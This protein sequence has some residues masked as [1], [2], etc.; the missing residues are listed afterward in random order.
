MPSVNSE[1]ITSSCWKALDAFYVFLL[2]IAETKTSSTALNSNNE[3]GI[4]VLFL[5]VEEKFAV[6]PH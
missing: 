6:F 5:N 4:P 2:S 3:S 1:S